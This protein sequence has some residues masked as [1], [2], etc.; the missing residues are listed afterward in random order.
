MKVKPKR[1][2][3]LKRLNNPAAH[4]NLDLVQ[5]LSFPDDATA[6]AEDVVVEPG[7]NL[8]NNLEPPLLEVAILQWG[9]RPPILLMS[10]P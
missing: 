4:K 9:M 1:P 7:T 8:D 6:I 5:A 10:T 3:K 2:R